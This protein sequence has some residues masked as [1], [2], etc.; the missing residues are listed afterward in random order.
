M[1]TSIVHNGTKTIVGFNLDLLNMEYRVTADAGRA[2]IEVKDEKEGWMPLFGANARGDFVAMPTCWP[3][4]DSSNPGPDR[5]E[6]LLIMDIDLL[7]EKKTFAETRK[8][9]ESGRVCSVP[10]TT[11]Q[12]QLS[13]A[14]GNVLQVTPG[15]GCVYLPRPDYA[16][17]TNFSPFKGKTET[18]PWMGANRYDTAMEALKKAPASFDVEDCFEV[19]KAVHQ[20]VCPTVV[21]M[22]FDVTERTVYWCENREWDNIQKQILT[23]PAD[24]AAPEPDGAD[25]ETEAEQAAREADGLRKKAILQKVNRIQKILIYVLTAVVL[26]VLIVVTVRTFSRNTAVLQAPVL[27]AAV[28]QTVWDVGPGI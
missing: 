9:A 12:A 19:L 13:D 24:A 11:F 2:A 25:D 22:V 5:S 3:F 20:T 10:G 21:S 7:L 1:C 16:V 26:A 6:N 15:Q 17:M 4:D 8:L 23:A 27:H 14:G 18:H 28:L